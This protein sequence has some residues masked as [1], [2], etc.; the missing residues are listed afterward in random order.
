MT[1]KS[2]EI[3]TPDGTAEAFVYQPDGEGA[4][5]GVLYLTDAGGIRPS[6]IDMAKR[7]AAQGYVVL[8]PNVFYRSG[9]LPVFKFPM[10]L[11][12]ERTMARFKEMISQVPP[13]A[14]ERDAPAYVDRLAREE[15]VSGGKMGVVGFCFTG[16][17]AMRTAA[18][19]PNEIAAAASFHGG[20]L[21]TEA[22]TSPHTVL[23]RIQARL[24]F[25]HAVEDRSMPE[26][27]IEKLD[28]AL[29]EWGGSYASE[30]YEG[31][32]HSWTV[33]D[34]PVYNE[35]QA[36]RAFEKLVELFDAALRGHSSESFK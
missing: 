1:E 11:G 27:A 13:E 18:V 10:K 4:W 33:L 29:Q 16:A 12:E 6:Q 36:E 3:V 34:S 2:I 14:M 35:P 19:C 25:A 23:P 5:P 21:W 20:G 26:E 17:M 8:L 9:K 15:S 24:Y 7:L 31:A 30:T 28:S 22:P 32:F